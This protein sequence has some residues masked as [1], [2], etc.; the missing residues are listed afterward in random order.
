MNTETIYDIA[1]IPFFPYAPGLLEWVILIALALGFVALFGYFSRRFRRRVRLEAYEGLRAELSRLISQSTETISSE[2]LSY[3]SLMIKR[4]L[5]MHERAEFTSMSAGELTD[6]LRNVSN[7]H[8]KTTLEILL[9]IDLM[10]F[11]PAA[12]SFSTELLR[13]LQ[14]SVRE[15]YQSKQR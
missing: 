6:Y 7:S 8:L 13:K 2:Q 1:D 14:D 3:A 5:S 4:F 12:E 9:G 11:R 10:R 15:Y